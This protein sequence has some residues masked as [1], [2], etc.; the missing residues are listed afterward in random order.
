VTAQAAFGSISRTASPNRVFS[1]R[2]FDLGP[3][4]TAAPEA[5]LGNSWLSEI[6]VRDIRV[7]A[8][9]NGLGNGLPTRE[10]LW[11]AGELFL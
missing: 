5:W 3:P 6:Y 11:R 7:T 1:R 9:L 10:L 4:R 2:H 8:Q